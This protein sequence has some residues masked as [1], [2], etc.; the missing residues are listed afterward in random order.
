MFF[1]LYFTWPKKIL[2][3]YHDN[4]VFNDNC[5]YFSY[6]ES[7]E[8]VIKNEKLSLYEDISCNFSCNNKK[9]YMCVYA[10][11]CAKSLYMVLLQQ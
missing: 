11:V 9:T 2:Q 7:T 10:C 8:I 4:L 5:N 3:K 6:G 1:F